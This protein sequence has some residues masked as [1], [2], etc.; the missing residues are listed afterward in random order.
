MEIGFVA[1]SVQDELNARIW[2][3]S[4]ALQ[5]M[6]GA[7]SSSR[8]IGAQQSMPKPEHSGRFS[9]DRPLPWVPDLVGPQFGTTNPSALIV[10][11]SYNGF[12]IGYSK[13]CGMMSAETYIE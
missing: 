10:G 4:P 3:E 5:R 11:S 1:R 7:T 2:A 12:M 9:A 8:G 6:I 13:R